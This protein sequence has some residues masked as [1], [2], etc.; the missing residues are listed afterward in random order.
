MGTSSNRSLHYRCRCKTFLASTPEYCSFMYPVG[1]EKENEKRRIERGERTEVYGT[2]PRS[3]TLICNPISGIPVLSEG[4]IKDNEP[5]IGHLHNAPVTLAIPL[6]VAP[7]HYST[8]SRANNYCPTCTELQ[9]ASTSN[10]NY[11]R[12]SKPAS[13]VIFGRTGTFLVEENPGNHSDERR[14]KPEREC[15]LKNF[16]AFVTEK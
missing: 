14:D 10:P 11:R 16:N 12:P 15:N 1:H 7:E 3:M 9:P 13:S 2:V 4:N 6:T 8:K 5:R